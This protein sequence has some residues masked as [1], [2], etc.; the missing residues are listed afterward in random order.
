MGAA[1]FSPATAAVHLQ[2]QWLSDT[3]GHSSGWASDGDLPGV[4]LFRTEVLF[5]ASSNRLGCPWDAPATQV[6]S[7]TLKAAAR[8]ES[9]SG[10][11]HGHSHIF[12]RQ[13]YVAAAQTLAATAVHHATGGGVCRGRVSGGVLTL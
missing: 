13:T 4:D 9:C 8:M 10:K 6:S 12:H 2:H 5:A 3:G 1:L 11:G 7:L